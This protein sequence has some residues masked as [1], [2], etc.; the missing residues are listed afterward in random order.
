MISGLFQRFQLADIFQWDLCNLAA[1]HAI[2]VLS[3]DQSKVDEALDYLDSGVGNGRLEHAVWEIHEEGGSGKPL[4]QNQESGRDQGH[5]LMNIGLLA[6]LAQQSYNQGND[7][8]G[9]MDSRIL[10]G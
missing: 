7:L 4:G 9:K 10:A 1:I 6:A 2:G 5:S 8:F 3:D